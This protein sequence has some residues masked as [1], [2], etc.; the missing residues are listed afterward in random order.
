[1]RHRQKRSPAEG[2]RFCRNGRGAFVCRSRR[3]PA[4]QEWLWRC[5]HCHDSK[6][7]L[8]FQSSPPATPGDFLHKRSP[9]RISGSQQQQCPTASPGA[10]R[11]ARTASSPRPPRPV[12]PQPLPVQ[13]ERRALSSARL[14]PSWGPKL[15]R[16][17]GPV[18]STARRSGNTSSQLIH[19][20]LSARARAPSRSV[21]PRNLVRPA[22]LIVRDSRRVSA[23]SR[24]TLA[25]LVSSVAPATSLSLSTSNLKQPTNKRTSSEPQGK[26]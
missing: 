12:G 20:Y 1:M 24:N 21:R 14:S 17:V 2:G 8:L 7:R 15:D 16:L 25:A 13:N 4:R 6:D 23:D 22:S 11:P 26:S 3:W 18:A 9:E 10:A 19:A 5:R